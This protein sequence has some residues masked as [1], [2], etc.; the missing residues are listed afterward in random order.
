MLEA[1][2]FAIAVVTLLVAIAALALGDKGNQ[3]VRQ[4]LAG[5]F[6]SL[7]VVFVLVGI[8]ALVGS[9]TGSAEP[10]VV[11]TPSEDNESPT[12]ATPPFNILTQS[13][14]DSLFGADNWF[15][16]PDREDGVGVKKLSA[17]FTVRS[18]LRYVDN[19]LG[20]F[21]LGETTTQ[22]AG[23]TAE[24]DTRLPR[25]ECPSF[26]LEALVVWSSA[27]SSDTEL[28]DRARFDAV[29]EAGNWTC[30]PD[31]SFGVKITYFSSL[32]AVEYPFTVVDAED[33]TRYGV[34]ETAPGGGGATVWLGGSIPRDQCP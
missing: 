2:S 12:R 6:L 23:A 8:F 19:W 1:A 20:R 13:D 15:C 5:F 29:F 10:P 26:Q 7:T 4:V 30:F 22:A 21:Q 18:P 14:I 31:Y 25:S 16:F 9:D 32:L 11:S 3:G 17:N 24:L 28:F 33:S 27:W 34:G